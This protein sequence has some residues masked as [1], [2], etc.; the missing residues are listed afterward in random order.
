METYQAPEVV[1]SYE[2]GELF[3]DAFASTSVF[4]GPPFTIK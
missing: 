4:T 1:A 2:A 3:C